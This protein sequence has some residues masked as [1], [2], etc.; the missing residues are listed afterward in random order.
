MKKLLTATLAL[1]LLAGIALAEE[2]E[3]FTYRTAQPEFPTNWSPHR[4]QTANDSAIT[5]YITSGFYAFDYNDTMDGYEMVPDAA[6]DF[7]TDVTAE[8]AG[9]IS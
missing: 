4:H 5:S 7:P 6:A 8:Y 3:R 2:E 9:T 1:L